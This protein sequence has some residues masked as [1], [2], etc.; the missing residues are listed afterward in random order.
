MANKTSIAHIECNGTGFFTIYTNDEFPFGFFGEGYSVREAKEDFIKTFEAFRDDHMETTGEYIEATFEFVYEM[1]AI[2]Q[3]CKSFISF[4]GLSK[5]TGI[6][7]AMLSQYA[8]GNRKPKEQMRKRIIDG[9]HEIG[10]VCMNVN[11]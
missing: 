8:C 6:S 7:K 9:I 3:E 2:L 10:A 1:S 4:A 5:V 11:N